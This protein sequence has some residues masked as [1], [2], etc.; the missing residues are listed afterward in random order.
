MKTILRRVG[1]LENKL[2]PKASL[3]ALHLAALREHQRQKQV[4][5]KAKG[6]FFADSSQD[7]KPATPNRWLAI[8]EQLRVYQKS[9]THK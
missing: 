1:S 8:A 2:A 4:E 7:N 9:G 6:Q 3:A 5:A